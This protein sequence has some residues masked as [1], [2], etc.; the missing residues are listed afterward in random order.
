MEVEAKV[1]GVQ[2]PGVLN[3]DGDMYIN[4]AL[5]RELYGLSMEGVP[6]EIAVQS[7]L[8]AVGNIDPAKIEAIRAEFKE[9]GFELMTIDDEV[10]LIRTFLDA[11]LAVFSIFGAIAL[12]A[13]SIGI[14]N[15]LFMAVQERTREIGLMKAMGLSAR[16]IFLAFSLE[17]ILLGFWGSVIGIA[18]SMVLGQMVNN[19]AHE[20]FLADFPT[21]QLVI[22]EPLRMA[23][24]ILIIM[25]IA[26]VAGTLPARK[27]A[28]KNPIDALRYE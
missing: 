27:A 4:A 12:L 9:M 17:A 19:I 10:G 28:R 18:V 7:D 24:I 22:F 11:M 13:A 14:I 21:F 1:A 23:A 5:D 2:A 6:D 20:S 26:F 8:V 25:L 15:T 3:M 16:K